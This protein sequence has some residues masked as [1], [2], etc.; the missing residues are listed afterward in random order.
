[1]DQSVSCSL[2]SAVWCNV[3]LRQSKAQRCNWRS[4]AKLGLY[5]TALAMMPEDLAEAGLQ[6]AKTGRISASALCICFRV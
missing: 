1:M 6:L 2:L 3:R 5:R 4:L